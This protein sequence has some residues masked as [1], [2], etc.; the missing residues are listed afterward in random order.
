MQATLNEN[1]LESIHRMIRQGAYSAAL[2]EL[3]R[4]AIEDD[5]DAL[6]IQC[7]L[8]LKNGKYPE[9][10]SLCT[11][12]LKQT[13]DH[14]L[15]C[16]RGIARSELGLWHSAVEDLALAHEIF[17]RAETERRIQFTT[18]RACESLSEGMRLDGGSF[19]DFLERARI[20]V[21][22]G[23]FQRAGRDLNQAE[24]MQ[25]GSS[26]LLFPRAQVA[27]ARGE[28]RQALRDLDIC[29]KNDPDNL[30]ALLLQARIKAERGRLRAALASLRRIAKDRKQDELSHLKIA[31]C[32]LVIGDLHGAIRDFGLILQRNPRS[33]G[34]SFGRGQ[35]RLD[36]RDYEHAIEDFQQAIHSGGANPVILAALGEAY[37]ARACGKDASRVFKQAIAMDEQCWQARLG[38]ARVRRMR[39]KTTDALKI[40]SGLARKYES[41]PEVHL[42]HGS[43]HF[44]EKDYVTAAECF[45][46]ALEHSQTATDQAVALYRRG[47]ARL[48]NGEI[49]AAAEDFGRA[50][51]RRPF[52][53]GTL[54]WRGYANAKLGKWADAMDDLQAAIDMNPMAAEQYQ[55]LGRFI[56]EQAIRYF[57]TQIREDRSDADIYFSRG[58]A[59]L[60]LENHDKAYLDF[61]Q[62][63]KLDP[64]H[65]RAQVRLGMLYLKDGQ[66]K[67]AYNL[68]SN[69]IKS[70]PEA[71]TLL[72]RAEAML[73]LG[74]IQPALIDIRDAIRTARENDRLYVRRGELYAAKGNLE[75]ALD[76][77]TL[78]I[79]LNHDNYQAFRE[80]AKLFRQ[81]GMLAEA[82][83][84]ITWS[85]HFYA[86]Q[87][88]LLEERG[89]L[90]LELKQ[91]QAAVSD[92]EAALADQPALEGWGL[93]ACTGR[94]AGLAKLGRGQEALVWLTK[95]I[96]RFEQPVDWAKLVKARAE[97]FLQLGRFERASADARIASKLN[98][99]PVFVADCY[100][101]RALCSFF[102]RDHKH[103]VSSLKKALEM[104]ENHS[105]AEQALDWFGQMA[106]QPPEDW[107]HPPKKI[108]PRRPK[109]DQGELRFDF[110]P[111]PWKIDPPMDLWIVRKDGDEFGPVPLSTVTDWVHQGRIDKLTQLFRADWGKWKSAV[112]VFPVLKKLPARLGE[113]SDP[114][115]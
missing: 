15:F 39:G 67:K 102:Y 88:D 17:P 109:A 58:M 83:Q 62:A 91:F 75:K 100:Y 40:V 61:D 3:R 82:I 74:V 23:D 115:K 43:I 97:I 46:R 108:R 32:R 21:F 70:S 92:F 7:F 44:D 64:A 1:H 10:D 59:N 54:V 68:F 80:R 6:K 69:A 31:H 5:L 89:K 18:R 73:Q 55:K 13:L 90:N 81:K 9:A 25:P 24:Q 36:C 35:A 63:L 8:L 103:A 93:D 2:T 113:Q 22:N 28:S 47:T 19:R 50:L 78:S 101:L 76:D 57:G 99:D 38:Y 11:R 114:L 106:D 26:E 29:L 87:P 107:R 33:S 98:R 86:R 95:S 42:F 14:E 111:E 49:P 30:D 20:H 85:L 56:A 12:L 72:L 53:V 37:L 65:A 112:R 105:R 104:D 94:A 16:W 84:D 71:N 79:A 27:Y 51:Q 66:S 48:E 60:F 34:A 52:H 41:Q 45:S 4:Q 110:D 96:H 77:F